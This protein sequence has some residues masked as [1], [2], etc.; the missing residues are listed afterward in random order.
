MLITFE[1]SNCTIFTLMKRFISTALILVVWNS[2]FSQKKEIELKSNVSSATVFLSSAQVTRKVKVALN[3]GVNEIKLVGLSQFI[4]PNSIQAKVSNSGVVILGVSHHQNFLSPSKEN[5]K[6]KAISDSLED[7]MFKIKIRETHR[8]VYTEEKDLLLKNKQIGGQ[9]SG[10]DIEDLMDMADFYRERLQELETKL[11]DIQL[12]VEK[13]QKEEYRLRQQL[14]ELNTNQTKHTGEIVV[15]LSSKGKQSSNMIVTYT[16]NN[17]GWLPKYD[18]RANDIKAPITLNYKADV[19]QNTG[20]D[21]KNIDISLSTGNPAVSQT[22]PDLYPWYLSYYSTP[23]PKRY[24][25]RA[26]AGAP[27]APTV[28]Y[29]SA[30]KEEVIDGIEMNK[31]IADFTTMTQNLVNT[32]FNIKMKYDV[33]SSGKATTVNILDIALPATYNYLAIPKRDKDAFLIA[34]IT[35]WGSHTLLPG[36]ANIYFEG[37]FVGESFINP[38]TTDDTLKVSL[39]RDLSIV[40]KREKID[41]F[42]KNTTFGGNKKSSRAYKL[43]VRNTKSTPIQL[44]LKDQVPLT[45]YKEI[46]VE[47]LDKGGAEYNE[48]TGELIWKLT[49]PPGET[50]DVSFKF[51]VKYPKD[52]V[53]NNL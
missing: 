3:N 11:L 8:K 19:Y 15:K 44:I 21:W 32:E 43:S 53:L 1:R 7:I 37:S 38:N 51:E 18:I 42:C 24:K 40:V 25:K 34:Q 5:Q 6:I 23:S 48:T 20:V 12:S 22:Q 29:T 52:K 2:F 27:A 47:I 46:E 4:N 33:L 31:T 41:E 49:I 26:Y 9:Q 36:D 13:L 35:D 50:V 10:V 14:T 39:G 30:D 45:S 28:N 17:A 16:V